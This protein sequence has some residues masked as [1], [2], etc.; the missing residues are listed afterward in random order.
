[1][2]MA[3]SREDYLLT[4]ITDIKG[5]ELALANVSHKAAMC[6]VPLPPTP[7]TFF[8]GSHQQTQL[9]HSWALQLE[10]KELW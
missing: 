8:P 2:F 6:R 10:M 9:L 3:A 5:M 7:L 1:M 4:L